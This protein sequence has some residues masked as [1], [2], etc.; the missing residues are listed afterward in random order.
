[1]DYDFEGLVLCFN[2]GH[3][4]LDPGNEVRPLID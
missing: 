4:K 2:T 3:V 1:M